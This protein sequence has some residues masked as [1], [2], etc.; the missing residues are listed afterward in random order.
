MK[1]SACAPR[2][3]LARHTISID[4]SFVRTL[5]SCQS[6]R[7]KYSAS[8]PTSAE[9]SAA[10]ERKCKLVEREDARSRTAVT[11]KRFP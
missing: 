4:L 11:G 6:M 1:T 3:A 7:A 10:C 9:S 2:L 5:A 8:K